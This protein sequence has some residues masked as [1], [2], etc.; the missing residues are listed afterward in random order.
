M[1]YIKTK[2]E[3]VIKDLK[4]FNIKHIL[5][6]GQIFR[7]QINKDIA[8]V[9]SKDKKAVV[10]TYDDKVVIESLDVDYFEKFFDLETDYAEIKQKLSEDPLLKDAVDFG[11][12]I[13]ILNN[14]S[15]EMIVSFIVS[16]NNNIPRI[17]KSIEFLCSKFGSNMGEYFAF[18]TL[19]QLKS[20][21]IEDY[22]TAGLGYRAEYMFETV[23]N[24]NDEMIENLK[25]METD[26]QLKFLIA[27]KGVGEK[28]ANCIM[29][30]GLG[31]K[32]VFPIDIWTHRVYNSIYNSNETNRKKIAKVL[33]DKYGNLSGYAQQ[34]FYYYF[35][36]NKLGA[37]KLS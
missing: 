1:K 13:R 32:N 26:N 33:T 22:K 29:L 8:V 37:N 20:A 7:Y 34:Y 2:N 10:K 35:R 23:Q 12:G 18:P 25:H 27:L 5:D 36:E 21:T 11:Y 24:L 19:E 31:V 9:Y 14:D 3:I 4:Q 17:K 16:A 15:F 6:C 30:F 28:V